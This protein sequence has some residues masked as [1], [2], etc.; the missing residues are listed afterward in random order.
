LQ[1]I[2]DYTRSPD[3][4]ASAAI[5]SRVFNATSF[6]NEEGITDWGD[7]WTSTTHVDDSGDGSNAAYVSFG[8]SL[9]YFA[10]PGTT[11]RQILDVH[12]AGAQRSNDKVGVAREPGAAAANA[13]FG[14]FYYK[15]PQGDILR[16]NNFVRCVRDID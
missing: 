12:G 14:D 2:V 5:D 7:Y 1:S 3:T 16:L 10:P 15:G 6:V 8:R 9:G 13:G 11:S 4:T